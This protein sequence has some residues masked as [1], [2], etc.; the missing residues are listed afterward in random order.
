[1]ETE[2]P[3]TWRYRHTFG[4]TPGAPVISLGEGN[5]PLVW[6]EVEGQKV[7]F[8]LEYLNPTGSF[9]DRG[10][11]VLISFLEAR[12]V[13]EA[14]EDSSGNAGA[15]FA[16]Y[17]AR[18]GL[19]GRVF[20]PASASGPKRAQISAYGAEI[21]AIPG[22]RSNAAEA[23]LHEVQRGTVYASHAYL[24]FG[25][26]GYA[27]VA[28]ELVEQLG[29]VPGTVLAPVGHGSLLLGLGRG[30]VSLIRA[31]VI[32]QLPRLVGVQALACAPIW[33]ISVYGHSGVSRVEEG[34]TLAEGIRVRFPVR[35]EA[36]LRMVEES[37]G[38]FLAVAEADIFP[39]RD[40]L[41]RQGFYVEPTSAVV[42]QAM[43]NLA[44]KMPEPI[45]VVLTGTGLKYSS[46]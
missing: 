9:K 5:T 11:A 34:E 35:G 14:V 18:A 32:D 45:A 44:G 38:T 17:A 10:S 27:T 6:G 46:Q 3:G 41:A 25:L 20:V 37:Q 31:G 26:V 12:G 4:L 24:P 19:K 22:P 8:K 42:W 16:A 15:S 40:Q 21:V 13:N 29:G 1:M 2:L 28:Y 23:V 36:L 7:A 30:F 39:G 43:K 33:A